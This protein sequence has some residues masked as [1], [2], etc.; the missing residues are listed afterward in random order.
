MTNLEALI[1][2]NGNVGSTAHHFDKA[3]SAREKMEGKSISLMS[4]MELA[5]LGSKQDC[6]KKRAVI[7]SAC[8]GRAQP[9]RIN[10]AGV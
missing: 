6:P 2:A 8:I 5:V 4:R 1:A 10:W 7:T 9:E 3:F